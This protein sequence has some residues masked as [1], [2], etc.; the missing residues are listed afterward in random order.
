MSFDM[1]EARQYYHW[2]TCT[3]CGVLQCYAGITKDTP[4]DDKDLVWEEYATEFGKKFLAPTLQLLQDNNCGVA[5]LCYLALKLL[6]IAGKSVQ[7]AEEASG[8]EDRPVGWY[9][10]IDDI[11][12][13]GGLM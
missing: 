1:S 7:L 3:L 13:K 12:K 11:M 8:T 6:E 5:E 9:T 10:N 2:L 4:P